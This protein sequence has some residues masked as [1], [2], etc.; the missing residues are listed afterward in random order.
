MTAFGH[1]DDQGHGIA[2][3]RTTV[4]EDTGTVLFDVP[5]VLVQLEDVDQFLANLR[6]RLSQ[7]PYQAGT[8]IIGAYCRVSRNMG[9][10]GGDTFGSID[11]RLSSV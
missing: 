4:R 10:V 6:A 9:A 7:A 8:E 2:N 1:S 11:V 5:L 3:G